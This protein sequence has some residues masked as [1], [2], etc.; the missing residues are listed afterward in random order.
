MIKL[1]CLIGL[2]IAP[3]LGGHS[4]DDAEDL[5]IQV[6]QIIEME[7][8]SDNLAR[9]T[10]ITTFV[11]DEEKQ[12]KTD[13]IEGTKEEVEAKIEA[14][15]GEGAHGN[16]HFKLDKSKGEISKTVSIEVEKKKS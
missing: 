11:E 7:A 16:H 2:V 1:I 8:T 4:S 5:G 12:Q 13:I 6:E 3:I 15:K 14:M 10:V 9:A